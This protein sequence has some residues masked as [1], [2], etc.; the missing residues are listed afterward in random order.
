MRE[1]LLNKIIKDEETGCWNYTGSLRKNTGYG[2]FYA[3]NKN[4][5]AHRVAYEVLVGPIP[6]GMLVC[7]TC[8]NKKCCNPEHLKIGTHQ[9][10]IQDAHRDG[11]CTYKNAKK[12]HCPTGHPYDEVNTKIYRNMRY[13]RQCERDRY[14]KGTS[15]SKLPVR[16]SHQP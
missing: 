4:L 16:P 15:V 2:Q 12:T 13:C 7:H 10:N 9:E 5:L 3:N 6:E 1:K 8:N 14:I 11:L